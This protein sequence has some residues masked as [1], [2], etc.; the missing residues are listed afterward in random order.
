MKMRLRF[1]NQRKLKPGSMVAKS[2]LWMHMCGCPAAFPPV[3]GS[4]SL[5]QHGTVCLQGYKTKLYIPITTGETMALANLFPETTHL[6]WSIT[7]TCFV[8]CTVL[9]KCE[10]GWQLWSTFCL[11]KYNKK[12]SCQVLQDI[13]TWANQLSAFFTVDH[14]LHLTATPHKVNL[15]ARNLRFPFRSTGNIKLPQLEHLA[16]QWHRCV[17]HTFN[18]VFFPTALHPVGAQIFCQCQWWHYRRVHFS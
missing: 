9:Y 17:C 12:K 1:L 5:T 16:S 11:I 10:L 18:G 14:I 4:S 13:S 15:N 7:S 6:R 8:S 3:L 2:V